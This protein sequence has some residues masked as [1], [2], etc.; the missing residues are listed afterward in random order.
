MSL[1]FVFDRNIEIIVSVLR[2]KKII[3]IIFKY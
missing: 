1:S 2:E 3:S